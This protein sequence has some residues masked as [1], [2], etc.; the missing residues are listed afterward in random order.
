MINEMNHNNLAFAT[1][2]SVQKAPLNVMNSGPIKK[3][4]DGVLAKFSLKNPEKINSSK[5]VGKEVELD[6]LGE[7]YD[8]VEIEGSVKVNGIERNIS[9][10]VYCKARDGSSAS[11]KRIK[12]TA[13][14]LKLLSALVFKRLLDFSKKR[15]ELNVLIGPR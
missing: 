4:L 9:R 2:S 5:L 8:A 13:P 1:N 6:W 10:R 3:E 15:P 7:N 14:L 11:R 12:R